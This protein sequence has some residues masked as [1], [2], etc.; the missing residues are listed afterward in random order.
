[1]RLHDWP[2]RLSALLASAAAR[3]FAWG[4]F[5]CCIFGCQVVQAMTGRVLMPGLPGSYS[6][7]ISAV[8]TLRA[9]GYRDLEEAMTDVLGS[10][11]PVGLAQRG[12][13]V[14]AAPR[15]IGVVDLT[16]GRVACLSSTRGLEY[17]PLM[18]GIASWHVE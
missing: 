13:L 3:S 12:D 4:E 15:A 8:R 7:E 16:G 18:S 1:M 9:H 6:D 2:S 5:D 17:I 10:R 11:R 14:L